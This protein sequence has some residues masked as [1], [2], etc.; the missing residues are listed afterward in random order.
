MGSD[1]KTDFLNVPLQRKSMHLYY[2]RNAILRKLK[3]AIPLFTGK[4][5]DV[6]C[7]HMPYKSTLLASDT[8]ISEYVG[9]DLADNR[10]YENRPDLSWDGAVI[11]LPNGSVDCAMATEVLEHCPY[12]EQTL[13]EIHRVLKPGGILFITVPFIWMLHE[14]PYDEYRYTPFALQRLV[15]SSKFKIIEL[16]ALGGWNASLAQFVANWLYYSDGNRQLRRIGKLLFF[17]IF[18][19]L[20]NRDRVPTEFE[21]GQMINGLACL[22]KKE[23]SR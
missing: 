16:S 5:L 11:P 18:K 12:P 6:G 4:L 1:L 3:E 7:G 15:E 2:V 22:A 23:D 17:P 10:S 9:M 8:N 21:T 14:V 13:T 19:L 20:I